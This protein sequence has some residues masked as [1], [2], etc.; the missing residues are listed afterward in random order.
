MVDKKAIQE[1]FH[2][3]FTSGHHSPDELVEIQIGD[4]G[5]VNVYEVTPGAGILLALPQQFPNGKLP[6]K[7]GVCNASL[8][9]N[10][11]GLTSLEGSP[12][13]VNGRFSASLNPLKDM[14]GGPIEVLRSV[15]FMQDF[16]VQ[17]LAG[18]PLK[19]GEHLRIIYHKNLPLLP[20]LVCKGGVMLSSTK[21]SHALLEQVE[22][23]IAQY[24][25]Q[26]RRAMFECQKALEDAGF[27]G[28]ARW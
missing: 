23:I 26:G 8:L 17:S 27:E 19:V 24:A 15:G 5:E 10:K 13:V 11:C 28:N 4:G 2:N 3:Y 12:P 16:P 18:F 25:G 21:H 14:T 7:F 20:A 1:L 6:V 22:D 9:L